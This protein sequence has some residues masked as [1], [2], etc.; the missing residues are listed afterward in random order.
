MVTRIV[1]PNQNGP[2]GTAAAMRMKSD[3]PGFVDQ[4]PAF[5][6][7]PRPDTTPGSPGV[8][9]G[10]SAGPVVGNPVV[11]APFTSSQAPQPTVAVTAGD[12]SAF[13]DDRPIHDNTPLLPGGT[14]G[15]SPDRTGAGEGKANHMRHPN[16]QNSPTGGAQ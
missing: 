10:E 9:A 7:F 4:L 6:A 5:G 8:T 1:M 12:T 16:N 13:S 15:N 2:A 14:V 3:E 11:T